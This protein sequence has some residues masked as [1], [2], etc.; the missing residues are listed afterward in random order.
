MEKIFALVAVGVG[1]LWALFQ[2]KPAAATPEPETTPARKSPAKPE[3]ESELF[4]EL[5]EAKPTAMSHLVALTDAA[6]ETE[7]KPLL[8][9]CHDA[10]RFL[11]DPTAA[12]KSKVPPK[13]EPKQATAPKTQPKTATV[14]GGSKPE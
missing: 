2:R 11:T 14:E 12:V 9:C 13:A 1:G 4:G 7:N 10:F 8:A 5:L 6:V 3:S